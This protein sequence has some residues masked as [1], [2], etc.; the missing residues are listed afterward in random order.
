MKL[1]TPIVAA[2]TLLAFSSVGLAD[3]HH[4]QA[5]VA[6]GLTF[7]AELEAAVNKAGHVI[8]DAPGQ[9]SPFSGLHL[10]TPATDTE[11]AQEHANV[12]PKGTDDVADCTEPEEE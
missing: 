5:T 2:A 10:C 9:G 6:G 4:F 3:D 12:K 11:S 8:P 1:L 7:D